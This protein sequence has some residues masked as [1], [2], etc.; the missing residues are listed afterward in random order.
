[1]DCRS[2]T[3]PWVTGRP[4]DAPQTRRCALASTTTAAF[5]GVDPP[6]AARGPACGTRLPRPVD[7]VQGLSERDLSVPTG[8]RDLDSQPGQFTA[9]PAVAP[10]GVP[11][12]GHPSRPGL[13]CD[14]LVFADETA[15]N[16]LALDP[17][18]GKVADRVVGLRRAECVAAVGSPSVAVRVYPART[19]RRCRSPKIGI[20]AA[21]TNL[22]A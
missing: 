12:F 19:D 4:Q 7:S 16:G 2:P 8:R 14:S 18:P 10:V 11:E 21:N 9:D 1:M 13:L 3:L 5:A 22:S 6:A 17:L 15:E 20:R